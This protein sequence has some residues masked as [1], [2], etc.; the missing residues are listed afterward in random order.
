MIQDKQQALL[1]LLGGWKDYVFEGLAQGHEA[2]Y[3]A[4]YVSFLE[5][6]YPK[7]TDALL[8][9]MEPAQFVREQ[10]L[11][12]FGGEP[13][14]KAVYGWTERDVLGHWEELRSCEEVMD[15]DLAEGAALEI[16]DDA[17]SR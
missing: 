12:L 4:E 17:L 7:A 9:G 5:R 8:A 3:P 15:Q 2:A 16:L 10:L 6:L 1:D 14:P 13:V 11:P